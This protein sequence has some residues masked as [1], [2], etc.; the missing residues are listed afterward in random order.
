VVRLAVEAEPPTLVFATQQEHVSRLAKRIAERGLRVLRVTG[1]TRDREAAAKALRRGEA[2]VVVAS[3][4]WEAGVD[5][6]ELR[7]VVNAAAGDSTVRALQ[8]LGRVLRTADGKARATYHDVLDTGAPI[9]SR[10]AQH[11]RASYER[12]G[13]HVRIEA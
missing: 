10:H 5:L 2:D 11:R 12:E 3:A 9:I 4:V 6:P 7:T 8:V 13:L 1:K